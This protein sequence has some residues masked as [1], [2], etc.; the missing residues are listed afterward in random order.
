[1]IPGTATDRE[2]LFLTARHSLEVAEGRRVTWSEVDRHYRDEALAYWRADLPRAIGLFARKAY[3][4]LSGRNY[5]EIFNP[6]LEISEGLI[7]RLRLVPL[8]TAWLVPMALVAVVVWLRSGKEYVPEL[9]L[10]AVPLLVTLV[11]RYSPRYRLPAVPVIVVGAAWV[12]L[13]VVRHRW[14]S[15]WS[16]GA[17]A[18]LL[19]TIALS[20]V[21]RTTGFDSLA[22]C[23]PEFEHSLGVCY[24]ADGDLEEAARHYRKAL[25]LKPELDESELSLADTLRK[26]GWRDEATEHVRHLLKRSPQSARAHSFL[27]ILLVEQQQLE[28]ATEHFRY[29]LQI[30]PNLADAH[31]NLGNVLSAQS[32]LDEAAEHYRTALQIRPDS[33]SALLGLA[34]IHLHESN[35]DAAAEVLRRVLRIDPGQ[36]PAR[37]QLAYLLLQQRK[38]ADAVAI[39]RQGCL[40]NPAD[41]AMANDLAWILATCP[42]A[43]VRDGQEAVH[44]ATRVRAG[45]A[46]PG[47]NVFDTLAAAYAEVGRFDLAVE[48]VRQAVELAEAAENAEL[49]ER[50]RERLSL[51]ESDRPYRDEAD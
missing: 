3:F 10:F 4:F 40:L 46:N 28:P 31:V 12:V 22:A 2:T 25:E 6:R 23:Q 1:M 36:T 38:Y 20:M 32:E 14:R 18:A 9:L 44:L 17:I 24:G 35:A 39:L 42:R 16:V 51:Y 50:L 13:Q 11:F 37:K 7:G 5:Y 33:M 27:G 47:A 15:G 45:T 43:E 41:T 26:L 19:V 49:A 48:A 34:R 29:A 21:N 8:Q 30:D